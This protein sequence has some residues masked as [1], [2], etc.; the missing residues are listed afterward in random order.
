VI[1]G[2]TIIPD[3]SPDQL[4]NYEF[5]IANEKHDENLS[6]TKLSS[7]ELAQIIKFLTYKKRSHYVF[8]TQK[9]GPIH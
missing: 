3:F 1:K 5:R 9:K 6:E 2:K 7:D 8:Q 4:S